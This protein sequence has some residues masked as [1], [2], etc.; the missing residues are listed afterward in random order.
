[1]TGLSTGS[2]LA[3]L[4]DL[5]QLTMA[6][7]YWKQ[8]T[9]DHLAVFICSSATHRLVVDTHW[10]QV[11]S[12]FSTTSSVFS[13]VLMIASIFPELCGNDGKP[14]FDA[15]FLEYLAGMRLK[16]DIDA[17]LEGTIAFPTNHCFEYVDRSSN[18]RFSKPLCSISS[19]FRR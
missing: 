2:S 5:Y 4:T 1:M 3:L 11:W 10:P 6:Y 17:M 7:G 19:T 15:P 12:R 14:L 13:S 18:A 9:A 16:I 8:R